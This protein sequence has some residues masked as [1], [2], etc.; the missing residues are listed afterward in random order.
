M[1]HLNNI[2]GSAFLCL[3]ALIWGL[4]FVAQSQ[5]ADKVPPFLFNALRSF[6]GAAF[7]FLL[8]LLR[9]FKSHT[10]I[11]PTEAPSRRQMLVG[12]AL[13]GLFLAISV[14]FQQFGLASYPA[15]A[16]SEARGGFLTALYVV[17]VP[18]IS[19]FLGKRI[20]LPMWGAVIIAIGGI[21]LLSLSGGIE[22]LYLGDVLM[23]FCAISF[24]LHILVVDRYAAPV[25]GILLSMMQFVVCGLLSLLL[26]LILE[27]NLIS[28]QNVLAATP[29]ILYL[30]IMSSGIAYTLQ[31]VGQRYADPPIASLSMSLESVFAAL[32]G[33][34]I[35]GNTLTPKELI[36]CGLVF[37]AIILAQIPQFFESKERKATPPVD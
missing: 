27:Q 36:G 23:F 2:K 24:S 31:I 15:G 1:K 30:G 21:Y 35:S 17:L 12:G 33:W 9:R 8:L 16:A 29:Q 26:S 10:P 6:I 28:L 5:A 13:C 14:N 22:S 3:A 7:L 19:V 34:L 20:K 25:G 11:F 37:G 18:I 4:A 32:G